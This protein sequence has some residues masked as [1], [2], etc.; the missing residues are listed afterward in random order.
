MMQQAER[1]ALAITPRVD[2]RCEAAAR[3]RRGLLILSPLF[4]PTA[5]GCARMI[6]VSTMSPDRSRLGFAYWRRYV[7]MAPS[8]EQRWPAS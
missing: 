2:F 5:Q 6:V 4:M 8:F 1:S 7:A 3:T